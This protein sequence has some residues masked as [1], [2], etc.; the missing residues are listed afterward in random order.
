M[1]SLDP[2]SDQGKTWAIASYAGL[3]F[4]LPI[5]LIPLIQRND[6]YALQHAKTATAVWL[7]TFAGSIALFMIYAVITAV[8]CGFGSVLLPIVGLP[9]V[10]SV[11]VGVHGLVL[12]INGSWDE[13]IGGFGFGESFFG[14]IDERPSGRLP[15]TL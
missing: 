14:S 2:V 8:T 15:P 5:G 7:G 1:T 10:W 3:L 12:S 11:V 9:W 6:R 4:G 13:P